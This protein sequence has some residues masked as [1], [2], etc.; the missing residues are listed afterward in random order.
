MPVQAPIPVIVEEEEITETEKPAKSNIAANIP[1]DAIV[2]LPSQISTRLYSRTSG[3]L[4]AGSRFVGEQKSGHNS[5]VVS[6]EIQH[7]DLRE[8]SLC[9]Y[10]NIKGLTQDWP[11][12]C[13]FFDAEIIGPKYSFLTRKWDADEAIDRQHWMKFPSFA[14]Y[15]RIFNNDSFVYDFENEDVVFMRWK[16]HFLVPDHQVKSIQGASFAGYYY[17]AYVKSRNSI[18]GFYYGL[19]PRPGPRTGRGL[20]SKRP[21]D[22]VSTIIAVASGKGGVGKSTTAVNLAVAFASLG[23]SAGLLDADLFGPSIPRM[24]NLSN[25]K[26]ELDST[27]KKLMPLSNYGVKCMSMG[28]LVDEDAAVVWRGLMVMKAIE[29]LV[30]DVDWSGTDVLVIDMP[31]GTGDTQLTITQILPLTGAVIVSTPQDVALADAKK[32]ISM[33]EKVNVPILGLVQNMSYFECPKCHSTTHIF[34]RDG[35][36]KT[37]KTLGIPVLA[38]LPLNADVC[39]TSDAG[40]PITVTQPNSIHAQAYT[41]MAK[42]L[43]DLM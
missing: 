29:Q 37:A 7:V 21:I 2:T 42:K 28:F 16:E 20:P 6:V 1:T 31:P 43:L 30:R 34:G 27:S 10:L 12:L 41:A 38:D 36:E 39:S 13:T 40:T 9:G 33:F 8:S 32:G 15:N 17:I 23:K 25:L 22:G 4:Y 24:M 5:Y 19:P 35:V 14:P 11:D 18:T 3:S 26:A